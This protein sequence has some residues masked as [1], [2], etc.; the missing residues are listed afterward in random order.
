[1]QQELE[2]EQVFFTMNEEH[3]YDLLPDLLIL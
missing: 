2:V 1:M 3:V